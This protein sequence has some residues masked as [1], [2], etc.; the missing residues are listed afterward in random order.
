MTLE[1]PCVELCRGDIL[2]GYAIFFSGSW[3]A[4]LRDGDNM[5]CIGRSFTSAGHAVKAIEAG[6]DWRKG[7]R[8]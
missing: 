5:I 1:V 6:F 7:P 4:Y 8:G 2:H 3:D